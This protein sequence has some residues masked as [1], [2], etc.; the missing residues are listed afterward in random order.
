MADVVVAQW[1]D[2]ASVERILAEHPSAVAAILC[3]P[4]AVNGGLIVAQDGFLEALRQAATRSGALLVFD[5]VIT[6]FR[7]ALGGAQERTGVR[8]DL[9]MFA[10]AIAG[11]I[12]LSAVTGSRSV[13]APIADG[14]LAHN[15]TFNGNPIAMAAGVASL[16]H[17]VEHRARR[18]IPS[19]TG[20][21]SGWR[22]RSGPRP[23]G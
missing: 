11:G 4:V 14:R 18:S 13:M 23:R 9:A 10:K 12:A 5:E 16:S 3:E 6:G 15:G 21:V 22:R 20:S 7:V 19:S 8:A 2:I 17:L 1:N